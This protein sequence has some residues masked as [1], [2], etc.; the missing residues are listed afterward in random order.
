MDA[1]FQPSLKQVVAQEVVAVQ[2]NV[3]VMLAKALEEV[4][5]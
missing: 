2:E 4:A 1:Q 3:K 5:A